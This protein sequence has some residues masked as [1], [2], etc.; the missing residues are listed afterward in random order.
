MYFIN[1][2]Y[3][4]INNKNYLQEMDMYIV[5]WNETS[6]FNENQQ[7]EILD[8]Q[9]YRNNLVRTKPRR[10]DKAKVGWIPE[11]FIDKKALS[12]KNTSTTSLVISK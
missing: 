2:K 11:C 1:F 10:D 12:S 5:N 3:N 9:D 7:I 8:C 6:I 4:L